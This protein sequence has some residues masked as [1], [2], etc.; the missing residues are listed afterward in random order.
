LG[1]IIDLENVNRELDSF[2]YTASHDLRAPLRA[3]SSFATFLEE[4]YKNSIDESGREYIEEIRKGAERMS[5]LIDDLLS[6]SRISRIHNP[7]EDVFV[8][9]IINAVL[10]RLKY[11]IDKSKAQVLIHGEMP[12]I[13]CDRIKMTEAV[14]NLISNA[15]KFSTG[16]DH[17]NQHGEFPRV[18]IGYD[19]QEAF[20]R[21]YVKDNGIGIDPEFH[22]KI[23]GVFKR[24]H[25][26]SEYEGTGAGLSIVL[27]IIQEHK[28]H[29]WV[30][31][32][33]NQGSTFYFTVAK[34][35]K[36]RK[37]TDSWAV[38]EGLVAQGD[39]Q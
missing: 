37:N 31:S 36:K 10:D 7:Y 8:T 32:Q 15:V 13:C 25:T 9:D 12:V 28:G 3:I 29:V 22:E 19:D 34:D 30:D 1:S 27:K 24:L 20:H 5:H 33:L 6:L 16:K 17:K 39:V 23:F 26:N 14:A 11:D 2:V 4:D 21:F 18:E 35:L 38:Q